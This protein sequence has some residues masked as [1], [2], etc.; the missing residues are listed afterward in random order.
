MLSPAPDGASKYM[1]QK[2]ARCQNA[3]VRLRNKFIVKFLV[4]CTAVD[5]LVKLSKGNVDALHSTIPAAWT[6]I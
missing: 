2:N 6:D 1:Q 4:E 3:A 5:T